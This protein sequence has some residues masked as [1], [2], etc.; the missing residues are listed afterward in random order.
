LVAVNDQFVQLR[1][2]KITDGNIM[3]EVLENAP[4]KDYEYFAVPKFVD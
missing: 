4:S 1:E 2:D 3:E